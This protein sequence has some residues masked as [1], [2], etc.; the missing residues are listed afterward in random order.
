MEKSTHLVVSS[1]PVLQNISY[2]QPAPPDFPLAGFSLIFATL[3]NGSHLIMQ[4][5][6]LLWWAIEEE[7][8]REEEEDLLVLGRVPVSS[9]DKLLSLGITDYRVQAGPLLVLHVN[10]T[11]ITGT[12]FRV[13]HA[14]NTHKRKNTRNNV[15]NNYPSGRQHSNRGSTKLKC[16]KTCNILNPSECTDNQ[17][18]LAAHFLQLHDESVPLL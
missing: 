1:R 8:V 9:L 3:R 6:T 4:D 16:I 12:T 5:K 13:L 18:S 14:G 11:S 10:R 2:S 15:A 17:Q 7:R